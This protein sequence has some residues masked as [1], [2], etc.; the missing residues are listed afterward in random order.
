[1]EGL[2]KTTKN[3][4][5]FGRSPGRDLNSGLSEYETVQY[6]FLFDEV[7]DSHRSPSIVRIV[8]SR[9]VARLWR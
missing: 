3:L 2:R 5:Q 4:G 9:H 7:C 1:V 8:K 6:I